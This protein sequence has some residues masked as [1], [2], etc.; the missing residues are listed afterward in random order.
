MLRQGLFANAQNLHFHFVGVGSYRAFVI[1][2]AARDGGDEFGQV[3]ARAGLG[4]G[5]R[6]AGGAQFVSDDTLQGVVAFT[7]EGFAKKVLLFS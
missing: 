4:Q 6:L 2:A 3:T 5:K 1:V 7:V